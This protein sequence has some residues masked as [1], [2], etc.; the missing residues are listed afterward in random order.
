MLWPTT[1]SSFFFVYLHVDHTRISVAIH[2][3]FF[4]SFFYSLTAP[5]F[6]CVCSTRCS[7]GLPFFFSFLDNYIWTAKLE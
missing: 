2:V 4:F 5:P 6:F 1:C 3:Y 7:T